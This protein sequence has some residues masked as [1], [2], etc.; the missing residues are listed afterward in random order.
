[1]SPNVIFGRAF[2]RARKMSAEESTD[3]AATALVCDEGLEITEAG[4]AATSL[5]PAEALR[6]SHAQ[7]LLH[8][9]KTEEAAELLTE[10]ITET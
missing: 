3:A 7:R 5:D 8:A 9:R 1:M 10:L 6:L 4:K 2:L